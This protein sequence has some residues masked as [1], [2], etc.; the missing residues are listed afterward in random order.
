MLFD[1]QTD[2]NRKKQQIIEFEKSNQVKDDDL[3]AL[4]ERIDILNEEIEQLK[5]E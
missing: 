3:S 2:V 4:K 5:E 1:C